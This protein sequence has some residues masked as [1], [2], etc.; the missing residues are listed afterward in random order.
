MLPKKYCTP[1]IEDVIRAR[2]VWFS[3]SSA[4]EVPTMM[5]PSAQIF[6]LMPIFKSIPVRNGT[7]VPSDLTP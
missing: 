4:M 5:K 1:V 7:K 3:F 6:M 2:S